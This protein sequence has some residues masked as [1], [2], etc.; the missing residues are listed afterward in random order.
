MINGVKGQI[1][2]AT[3]ADFTAKDAAKIHIGSMARALCEIGYSVRLAAS[4]FPG[5]E[6][7][8]KNYFFNHSYQLMTIPHWRGPKLAS[9]SFAIK[10]ALI[11]GRKEILY[12]RHLPTA[13]AAVFFGKRVIVELHS[14]LQRRYSQLMLAALL[15]FQSALAFVVI[16]HA[17]KN[18]YCG[19]LPTNLHRKIRVLPDAA[20]DVTIAEDVRSVLK[21]SYGL[22]DKFIVGYSGSFL[23]G[24]G[25]ETVLRVAK[26][27]P[28]FQFLIV[29]G[30]RAEIEQLQAL[31]GATDN[32]TFTGYLPTESVQVA[33]SCFDVALLPNAM[34]VLVNKDK[35]DI[36][37]WTSP[38][39]MFEYMAQGRPI[40]CSHLPVLLE[41]L[42][43][44]ETCL[45]AWPDDIEGWAD[46]VLALHADHTLRHRLGSAARDAFLKSFTWKER[47]MGVHKIICS[48]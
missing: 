47:A 30:T 5:C 32:V 25:V 40:V 2:Y 13:F 20:F 10:T 38:L 39:K 16:S 31:H 48:T 15:L 1:L 44:N 28:D 11:A 26:R 14:P 41:V 43:E 12:T 37:R 19:L 27:L 8:E 34:K 3:P 6:E 45:T 35:E 7:M 29:G 22:S 46:C 4:R 42:I 9:M 18:E 17:L 21:R 23:P 24:K 33:I 36:G